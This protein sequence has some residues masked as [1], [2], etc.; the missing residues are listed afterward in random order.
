[1]MKFC[2]GVKVPDGKTVQ[3]VMYIAVSVQDFFGSG[4][5]FSDFPLTCVFVLKIALWNSRDSM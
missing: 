1:M 5:E 3:I 4:V 2:I